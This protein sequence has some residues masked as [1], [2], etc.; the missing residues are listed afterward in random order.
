MSR[1]VYISCEFEER[2]LPEVEALCQYLRAVQSTI[3]IEFR[4]HPWGSYRLLER[5]IEACDAFV[6]VPAKATFQSGA[7]QLMWYAHRLRYSRMEAVPRVFALELTSCEM[8]T[9]PFP[10]LYFEWL[11]PGNYAA[12]LEDLPFVNDARTGQEQEW[13]QL[14]EQL[15]EQFE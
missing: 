8:T 3:H 15:R 7:S 12:L 11:N 9:P 5:S 1:H 13:R 14:Y 4:P 10:S 2:Q 6:A